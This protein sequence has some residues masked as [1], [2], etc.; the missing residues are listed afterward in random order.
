[1]NCR[2]VKDRERAVVSRNQ[3]TNLGTAKDH[4]FGALLRECLA[5][6]ES[7]VARGVAEGTEAQL[8]KDDLVNAHPVGL[9]GDQTFNAEL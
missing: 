5:P 6:A 3:Q 8:F 1:M 9:V 7:L 4:P 2:G